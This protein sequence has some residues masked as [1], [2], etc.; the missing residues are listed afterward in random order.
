MRIMMFLVGLTLVA[1]GLFQ[2][3]AANKM[4]QRRNYYGRERTTS[5]YGPI[6]NAFSAEDGAKAIGFGGLLVLLA[7]LGGRRRKPNGSDP[8]R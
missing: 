5:Y 1:F 6:A 8:G 3:F 2:L 4:D 7:A